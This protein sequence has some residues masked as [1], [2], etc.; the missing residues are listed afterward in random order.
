MA[1]TL[2][3]PAMQ[4]GREYSTLPDGKKVYL[5]TTGKLVCEH[6]ECSSTICYWLAIEKKAA[7]QG[8]PCPPRGGS[9][10]LSACD[11]QTT[12][13]LNTK[14]CGD[15]LP[16]APPPSLFAFLEDQGEELTV[17]KGREA[18]RIPHLPGP[19]FIT[20]TGKLL[21][22]TWSKSPITHYQ[23]ANNISLVPITHMWMRAEAPPGASR[24]FQRHPAGQVS[25]QEAS[26]VGYE[27]AKGT[28][29]LLILDE[30]CSQQAGQF[31]DTAS[32]SVIGR[33]LTEKCISL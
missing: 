28:G 8:N 15:I 30:V 16:P 33:V 32:S 18:R 17:I 23:T 13:G 6:G 19:V 31:Y 5:T 26:A 4:F 21:L 11:C 3:L 24:I 14:L 25:R 12:E 1:N 7:G 22:P 2:L 20:S 9:R 10:G 29:M 27:R